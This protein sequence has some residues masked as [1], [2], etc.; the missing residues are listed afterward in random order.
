MVLA[1]LLVSD[2]MDEKTFNLI[3]DSRS[4]RSIHHRVALEAVKFL[5]ENLANIF[6]KYYEGLLVGS[7]APDEIFKDYKNH[8]LFMPEKWGGA[9]KAV[10]DWFN[11]TVSALKNKRWEKAVFAAGVMSHYIADINH[12]LHTGQTEEEG[13]IHSF[14]EWGAAEIYLDLRKDMIINPPEQINKIKDYVIK[15]ANEANNSYIFV[16]ENYDLEQGQNSNWGK[17]YNDALKAKITQRI[18]SA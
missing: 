17:G 13:L 1:D 2:F 9:P 6:L 10:N 7:T 12:P 18:A 4:T 14:T 15:S 11:K 3:F 8:V 5:D 16:I